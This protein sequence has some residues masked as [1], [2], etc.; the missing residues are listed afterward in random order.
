MVYQ[1][2]YEENFRFFNFW[3]A[4]ESSLYFVIIGYYFLLFAYFL[5]MRYRTSKKLYW[6]FFSLLFLS[7]AVSRAFFIGY[8]FYIPE[9]E[10][11]LE[12]G[13]LISL[14]M[15]YYR[16][17][18]FF[19]WIGVACAM[20]LLGIL[21]FPPETELDQKT[22]KRNDEKFNLGPKMKM[23]LRI[24]LIAVPVFV[25]ILALILPD[26]LLIDP[27]L[28]EKYDYDINVQT[29]NI[30]F[31]PYPLGR[32]IFLLLII[33]FVAIIPFIF[34]YLAW[35]TF[36]VLRKSYALNAIGFFIYYAGRIAQ[37]IFESVGWHHI[38]ATVPPLMILG[39]LLIIVIANN[40]EQL[41]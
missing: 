8:Y 10:G 36:G 27:E 19:T 38:G 20:G 41:K 6:L 18:T 4:I 16:L 30:G 39:S 29:I 28:I 34:V 13:E 31:G 15:L 2:P 17:A 12:K 37:G 11:T 32:F 24:V 3:D 1:A 22:A 25:S 26:N 21:L 23:F 5:I 33:A 7:F 40:Y 14:L 35:K 9:L